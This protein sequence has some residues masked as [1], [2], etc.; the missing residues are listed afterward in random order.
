MKDQMNVEKTR[1]HINIPIFIPHVGCNNSCVFC[2]QRKISGKAFFDV[3]SVESELEAAV[4]T[5]DYSACDVEIA[6]F[7]GSFTGIDRGDMIYLLRLAEK[8]ISAGKAQSVR[9]STRPD[10]I[11]REIL[12]ILK[13]H[14]VTDIELGIQSMSDRVLEA[15]KR[16]HTAEKSR[17][18]CRMIN[19]YRFNLVGQMMIG[20]PASTEEDEVRTAEEIAELCG[21]ARIYPTVVFCETELCEMM[22]QGIYKPLDFDDALV[23]SANVL[24]V[25]AEKNIPVIRL[26]LCASD[27]LFEEGTIVGGAYHSA[28]GEMV[29]SELY[30]RRM[31]KYID[32]NFGGDISGKEIRVYVPVGEVSKVSGQ[33]KANKIRLMKEYNVKKVRIIENREL[34]CYNIRIEQC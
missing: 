20:L 11:D 8:Y 5:I 3:K 25:F 9:L 31:K 19:E 22:R 24:E 34:F 10:Y 21:G 30:Y 15:S 14:G 6:F 16:G 26:G 29:Y 23:R 33:K 13:S 28:F 4:S 7:G 17:E 12:D 27:N 2:N 1:R 32:R 18:S